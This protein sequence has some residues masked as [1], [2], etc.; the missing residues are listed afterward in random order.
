MTVQLTPHIAIDDD[1]L[2]W[3]QI[4]AQGAIDIDLAWR[5]IDVVIATNHQG[6]R[7]VDVIHH[8]SEIVGG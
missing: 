3:Q 8:H 2:D 5:V 7:H 1:E 4:R 6:H